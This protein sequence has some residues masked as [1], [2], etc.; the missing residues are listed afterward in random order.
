MY[1]KRHCDNE[2]NTTELV[3]GCKLLQPVYS[4]KQG[5]CVM[6]GRDVA[7]RVDVVVKT[8]TEPANH[9]AIERFRREAVILDLLSHP[10]IVRLRRYRDQS[11]RAMVLEHI[12]SVQLTQ[13]V[14]E[15]G[16]LTP[17]A[18]CAIVEDIAAALDAAHS[19]GVFHRDIRPENI[20]IPKRGHA[21]LIDF[22]VARMDG[23]PEITLHGESLRDHAYI[24]PEQ[25]RGAVNADARSD[26]YSLAS[27][28]YFALTGRPPRPRVE[29]GD[30]LTRIPMPGA[31]TEI[32]A[33]IARGMSGNP[34]NR[35]PSAGQMAADLRAAAAQDDRRKSLQFP[36]R[37]LWK[38]AALPIALMVLAAATYRPPVI[39]KRPVGVSASLTHGVPKVS[40]LP[41]F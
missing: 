29:I 4:E 13:Y 12:S 11:P 5:V 17:S 38:M 41:H 15:H 9:V 36:A 37:S 26:V 40:A 23:E 35:Y 30:T 6:R 10:N 3:A 28:A 25:L 16:A 32:A 24:S 22:G 8:M 19:H 33:V 1:P 31:R 7:A 2:V 39:H 20:L 27:V 21:R 34:A 18:L 14:K